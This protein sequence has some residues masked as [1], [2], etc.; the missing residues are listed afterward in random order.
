LPI[1]AKVFSLQVEYSKLFKDKDLHFDSV[2]Y[3]K[4]VM[5]LWKPKSWNW[6]SISR[7]L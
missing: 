2:P 7:N 3:S 6:S 4:D 5:L 1:T